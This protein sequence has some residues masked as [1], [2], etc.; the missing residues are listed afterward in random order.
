MMMTWL[1]LPLL[2]SWMMVLLLM[3]MHLMSEAAGACLKGWHAGCMPV[4]APPVRM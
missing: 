4:A 2:R 1:L 3:M